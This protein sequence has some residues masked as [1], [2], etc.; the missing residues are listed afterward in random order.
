M[1][2]VLRVL[3]VLFSRPWLIG[4]GSLLLQ[5][6]VGVE[7]PLHHSNAAIILISGFKWGAVGGGRQGREAGEGETGEAWWVKLLE[8]SG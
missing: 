7:V 2:D 8:V 5:G 1:L 6:F 4:R 3:L